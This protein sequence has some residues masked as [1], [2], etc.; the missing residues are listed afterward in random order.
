MAIVLDVI[1][2]TLTRT[3]FVKPPDWVRQRSSMPRA[4]V[5]F[6]ANTT[7]SAKPLNDQQELQATVDLDGQFAYRLVDFSAFV[8]QDVANN[9]TP[10]GY[11]ELFNGI[12]NLPPNHVNRHPVQLEDTLRID[13]AVRMWC[14]R[15]PHGARPQYVIQVGPAGG[16]P[17]LRFETVNES[18][19]AGGTG[20]FGCHITFFEY[21]IEQA[22]YFAMHYPTLVFNR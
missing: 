18:S 5:N 10:I 8:T 3:V 15:F 1:P 9:W 2:T 21:E 20:A 14:A 7:I 16:A 11:L 22:Q 12:R 17:I 4:L 13:P 6:T 19:P